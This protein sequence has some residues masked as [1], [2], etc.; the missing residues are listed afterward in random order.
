LTVC[1]SQPVVGLE[2]CQ[3]ALAE[4]DLMLR[5]AAISAIGSVGAGAASIVPA[6]VR[7]L[8][9]ASPAD[10]AMYARALGKVGPDARDAVPALCAALGNDSP[11]VGTAAAEALG[12]I[13]ATGALAA[14]TAAAADPARPALKQ[15]AGRAA[16]RIQNIL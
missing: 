12:Q 4:D 9:G 5:E 6:L 3:L 13:R 14:L 15:A 16:A 11:A 8:Q 2:L 10:R 1:R 7:G